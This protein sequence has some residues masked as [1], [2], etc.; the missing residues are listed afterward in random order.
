MKKTKKKHIKEIEYHS[1]FLRSV[2]NN[3][4]A[5][6]KIALA[7]LNLL[8]AGET[9]NMALDDYRG[10]L[11]YEVRERMDRGEKVNINKEVNEVWNKEEKVKKSITHQ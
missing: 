6:N 7:K 4:S 5:K 2:G 11:F 3:L 9:F 8:Q 1:E 10:A